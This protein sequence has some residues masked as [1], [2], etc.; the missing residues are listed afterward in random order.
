MLSQT[1]GGLVSKPHYQNVRGM[2]DIL[3][4]AHLAFNYITDSFKTLVIAAGYGQITTP[5]LEETAVFARAVGADTDIV[6]KE[7]YSF[8]DRS[9]KSLSLRPEGTAGVVRAYIQHGMGSWPQPV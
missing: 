9:G 4:E 8:D 7:M 5:V 1:L 3:P 6:S 2:N